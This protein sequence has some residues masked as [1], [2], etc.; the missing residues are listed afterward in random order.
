MSTTT[1]AHVLAGG[2]GKLMYGGARHMS[3]G[4]ASSVRPR[5]AAF[6]LAASV[7]LSFGL[8]LVLRIHFMVVDDSLLA[9][10][11]AGAY[12]PGTSQY[13][14]FP[15]ITVGWLLS[16]LYSIAPFLPWY[17]LLVVGL[18][19]LSFWMAGL[20]LCRAR[21]SA[22]WF[23]ALALAEVLASCLV[24]YTVSAALATAVGVCCLARPPEH[25]RAAWV[26]ASAALA[27]AG[28][29]LRA[30]S[31][32]VALLVAIPV[33]AS[34]ASREGRVR[35]AALLAVVLLACAAASALNGWAYA[36]SPRD[37]DSL[38]R[39]DD[40]HRMVDYA[41]VAWDAHAAE[42]ERIGWS[43]ND[44]EAYYSWTLAD[45]D[46]YSVE[47]LGKL[48]QMLPLAE[49]YQVSPLGLLK[50]IAKPRGALALMSVL[51]L[52]VLASP[53]GSAGATWRRWTP[54]FVVLC[55]TAGYVALVVRQRVVGNALAALLVPSIVCVC[56]AYAG[57]PHS[58][59]GEATNPEPGHRRKA[60]MG[61]CALLY[62]L[63]TVAFAASLMKAPG[64]GDSTLD[65]SVDS[66]MER[67]PN[68]LVAT[69]ASFQFMR[70]R[71]V[72]ELSVPERFLQ[73][74]KVG[75]W[76]I[77]GTRWY[78]QLERWGVDPRH[79]LLEL[80]AKDNIVF[81][82]DDDRQLGLVETFITEHTG[83]AVT[84]DEVAELEGGGTLYRL[85]Y[86]DD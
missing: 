57:G 63:S 71:P 25:H 72:F 18:E 36:Q 7:A 62:L 78:S 49:K 51:A 14:L 15:N 44:L 66:W 48:G 21:V 19:C 42:L 82:P 86:S 43:K 67:H 54:L 35:T 9:M 38:T 22:R 50:G 75:S 33:V 1:E 53:L 34:T 59:G 83:R 81:L 84:A 17:A 20:M 80:A 73:T 85:R 60:V 6:L 2:F 58:S 64:G 61:A 8:M 69:G 11:A 77:D 68:E 37:M 70:D 40:S 28:F 12:G 3:K 10:I 45:F 56:V 52:A 4:G 13:L 31:M 26:V 39:Q 24:T 79:L 46:V 55:F 74:V 41:P 65:R 29:L 47:N 76:S 27:L 32:A 16:G 23:A 5:A 30:P